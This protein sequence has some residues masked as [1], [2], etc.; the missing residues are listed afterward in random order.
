MADKQQSKPQGDQNNGGSWQD[1]AREAGQKV[2]ETGDRLG[3]SVQHG[4]DAAREEAMHR[5]RQTE[6]MIAR[7]PASSVALGFGVGVGLGVLLSVLL[8]RREETWYDRY[9]P[10]AWR[11]RLRD[12]PDY[13]RSSADRL[14]DIP[15]EVARHIPHR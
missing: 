1:R 7:N 14:R 8:T 15:A 4:Y 13:M 2:R 9:V 6:G 12:V 3:D 11:D 5:Y 10:D